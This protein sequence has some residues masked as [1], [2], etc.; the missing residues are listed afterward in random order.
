MSQQEKKSPGLTLVDIVREP[1]ILRH[2]AQV[3]DVELSLFAAMHSLWPQLAAYLDSKSLHQSKHNFQ[4]SGHK[5]MWLE[6]RRQD[7]YGMLVDIKTT[8]RTM[9]V[10]HVEAHMICE[11][12][13][14]TLFVSPTDTSTLF[15]QFGSKQSHLAI[16]KF[17]AWL[18]GDES[19][20]AMW[21]AGQVIKTTENLKPTQPRGFCAVAVYK[22]C[23]TLALPFLL[24]A[25]CIPS[26]ESQEQDSD[27]LLA[28][29]RIY[30]REDQSEQADIVV[31]N[32]PDNMP[33]KSYLLSGHGRPALLVGKD[34]KVLSNVDV[35]VAVITKVFRMDQAGTSD[36]LP[37]LSE[38]LLTLVKDLSRLAENSA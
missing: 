8:M 22:A 16:P 1:S 36:Q 3:Y 5:V 10:L 15:G 6:A 18:D 34:V 28:T 11:L 23:L 27:P 20:Y 2:S 32:G 19:R 31:L 33:V 25:I 12:F 30:G 14:M 35:I 9:N 7:L 17:R 26:G 13:M 24:D 21:H 4:N 38:K 29:A 37:L